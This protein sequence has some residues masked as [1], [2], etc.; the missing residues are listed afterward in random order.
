MDPS[1]YGKAM[2]GLESEVVTLME[3]YGKEVN[4]LRY[5]PQLILHYQRYTGLLL[6]TGFVLL[7][8]YL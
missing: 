2:Q 3:I 1:D 8:K 4:N 5:V 7:L 6:S